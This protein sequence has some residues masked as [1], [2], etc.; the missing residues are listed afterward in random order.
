MT[1]DDPE[2]ADRTRPYSILVQGT[3]IGHYRIL[4]R[5]GAGGMGEVYLADDTRLHRR[6]ALK[7]LSVGCCDDETSKERFHREAEAAARLS[8]P[9]IIT[10]FEI[11]EYNGRPFIAMEYIEGESLGQ[12]FGKA[13]HS[14]EAIVV[15]AVQIADGLAAAHGQGVTH[16][17]IK[18]SNIMMDASGRARIF[19]FGL[20][21]VRG[22][23]RLTSP[24]S[25]MGTIYYMSPEQTRGE[26][27]DH[28]TDIFSFGVVLYEMITGQHPFRGDSEPVVMNA[29]AQIEPEPLARYKA[30]V[31]DEL[32]R[33]VTKM[34]V[35]DPARRYQS[36]ADLAAD[37]KGVLAGGTV[38]KTGA[39]RR[40]WQ[41]F[42]LVSALFALA[43]TAGYWMAHEYL[44]PR[45]P[46]PGRHL[47]AV[48]PFAVL[49]PDSA[50]SDWPE[51]I[52]TLMTSNLTGAADCGVVDPLSFKTLVE[53]EFGSADPPRDARFFEF[54]RK[55]NIS[56][57]VDGMLIDVAGGTLVQVSIVD[58]GTGEH[59]FDC[60]ERVADESDLPRG[61]DTLSRTVLAYL[62]TQILQAGQ[63]RDLQPWLSRRSIDLGALKAFMQ[64]CQFVYKGIPGS[65]AY[66]QHAI[67]L[68]SSFIAPRVWLISGLVREGRIE[69]AR[70]HY[71]MLSRLRREANPFEQAMI[72]WAGAFLS[73]DNLSQVTSLQLALSYS[74]GNN[75]LLY[76]LAQSQYVLG[77]HL[78]VIET[79]TPVIEA[80]W[81]FSQA[82]YLLGAGYSA[83]C[84]YDKARK[85]LQASLSL[86]TVYPYTYGLLSALACRERDSATAAKYENLFVK[87]LL[88]RQVP[89][90]QIYSMLADNYLQLTA[91]TDAIRCYRIAIEA[92]PQIAKYHAD[93]GEALCQSGDTAQ[94]VEEFLR[95]ITLD[96]TLTFSY[97]MLGDIY[98]RQGEAGKAKEYYRAFIARDSTSADAVEVLRRLA[99]LSP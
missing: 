88:T 67:T 61:I 26:A 3:P 56:T 68:D 29:I 83:L 51:I 15:V 32:Q 49:K 85:V 53:G 70:R 50:R 91:A 39:S 5:L 36:A 82:H 89:L 44:V 90:D 14:L 40:L 76:Q 12:K 24:G 19:D 18:P 54:L 93:L 37:L 28:R 46:P 23:K 97:R 17:D 78:G 79:L 99:R 58:P 62:Q 30:G 7:F 1:H 21:T 98:D 11:N 84:Q 63:T 77:N 6:V 31:P 8:H 16:R 9:N 34:L 81:S 59:L 92:H 87:E 35:K 41:R 13:P 33:I 95:A 69:E 57:F 64:A 71:E 25:T 65:G 86:P 52:Q 38:V 10:I 47:L 60:K 4:S 22:T 94:A 42:V 55:R 20:A 75:I 73:G 74:P 43:L 2:S 27:L 66:L 96:S 48:L 72:Q 80:K 45:K